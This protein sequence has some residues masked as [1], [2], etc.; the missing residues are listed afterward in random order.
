M[1]R[2]Q[3]IQMPVPGRGRQG[4]R[5]CSVSGSVKTSPANQGSSLA[6]LP[7]IPGPAQCPAPRISECSWNPYYPHFCKCAF[8]VSHQSLDIQERSI[9]WLEGRRETF[10]LGSGRF[11]ALLWEPVSGGTGDVSCTCS[12]RGCSCHPE[13]AAA[14]E[15]TSSEQQGHLPKIAEA[16]SPRTSAGPGA[17]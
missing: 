5:V 1:C 16:L 13:P 14:S 11:S 17:G 10:C 4:Q 9:P 3:W 8:K 12:P 7:S 6:H 15:E 2:G